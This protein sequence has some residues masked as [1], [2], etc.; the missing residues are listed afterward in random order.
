VSR[1]RTERLLN[2]VLCLLSTRRFLTAAQIARTVAGYEHDQD[3]PKEHEAFQRMFERDK[4]ELRDLGIP[5]E[6]GTTS[7]FDSEPGYR[8]AQR[9][10]ALPD[11]HLLPDEAAAVGLA[12]RLWQSAGL[13]SAA[14]SALVKLKAA[15]IDVDPHATLGI[16]PVLS[17]EP[18]IDAILAAVRARRAVSFDYRGGRDD[19]AARR[20]VQPW[21]AVSWHGRWYVVG[22][23][24]D[25]GAERVFRMSRILGSITLTGPTNAYDPPVE[26]DL[27]AFVVRFAGATASSGTATVLVRTGAGAGLRRWASQARE[28]TAEDDVVAA[29]GGWDL[30]R[31]EFADPQALAMR[32]AGY[33][34]DVVALEPEVVRSAVVHR[35]SARA[36]VPA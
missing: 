11:I 14:S 5:V 34:A 6:T 22:W 20:S 24:T 9:D 29:G 30:L 28:A 35:L 19:A 10:Y 25:R 23:D 7:V 4:A 1:R 15:G 3:D 31:L 18:Q 12:T 17:A 16:E 32:L 26:V 21:G 8:I 2:L 13:A 27:R 36:G 33:G